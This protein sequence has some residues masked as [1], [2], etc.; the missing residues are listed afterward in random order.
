MEWDP[1][2]AT[3]GVVSYYQRWELWFLTHGERTYT[4]QAD[5]KKIT[6]DFRSLKYA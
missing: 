4:L 2:S 1:L 3:E 6:P 5:L